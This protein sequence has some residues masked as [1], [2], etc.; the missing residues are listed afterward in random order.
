MANTRKTCCKA[1]VSYRMQVKNV[2]QHATFIAAAPSLSLYAANRG[3]WGISI[4][5]QAQTQQKLQ[6]AQLTSKSS[7]N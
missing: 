3:G 6:L 5:P 1:S 4:T 2:N 7:H